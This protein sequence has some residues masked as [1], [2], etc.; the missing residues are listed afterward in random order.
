MWGL[1]LHRAS[2]AAAGSALAGAGYYAAAPLRPPHAAPTLP[3]GASSSSYALAAAD[4]A[5]LRGSLVS[6]VLAEPAP[7]AMRRTPSAPDPGRR[8]RVAVFGGSFN[9][10]TNAHLNC[11]AEIIHSKL[12]DEVWITPCG[13]RPDKPSLKTSALDRLIMAHL[14]VD[15]TF[16]SRFGVKVCDEEI[17]QPRNIPSLILMRQLTVKHPSIDFSF[18]VGSDLIPTLHQWDAPGCPGRWEGV[19]DAGRV[20]MKECRFLVID[21]PGEPINGE[22]PAN[23]ELI[24]PAL[25]SRGSRLTET[26]LSSSEV[27]HRMRG[28]DDIVRYELRRGELSRSE[29][30]S[31]SWYDEAEGL[32]PPSVLGHIVR[33]GLYA[34]DDETG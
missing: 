20:F 15:T 29:Q 25:A 32:V 26:F 14:A 1:L 31:K 4:S 8:K 33:Y 27:R 21:R 10:I 6:T 24:A 23:F 17:H 18:V 11:A 16:G 12:A 5:P 3:L 13:I 7:E 9:P 22:L 19:R 2:L 30:T 28:A 34:R